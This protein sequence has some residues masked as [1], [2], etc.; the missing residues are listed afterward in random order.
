MHPSGSEPAIPR[1]TAL[2]ASRAGAVAGSRYAGRVSAVLRSVMRTHT[3]STRVDQ[4]ARPVWSVA[5]GRAIRR[6]RH[7]GSLGSH[8]IEDVFDVLAGME[9]KPRQLR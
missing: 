6:S 2:V 8:V 4:T 3:L 5:V 1:L 7:S 9:I